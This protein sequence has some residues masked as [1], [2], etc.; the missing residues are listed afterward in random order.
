MSTNL[1]RDRPSGGTRRKCGPPAR[2]GDGQR[3]AFAAAPPDQ[4]TNM[5]RRAPSRPRERLCQRAIPGP[6]RTSLT[7][8]DRLPA[9]GKGIG[10]SRA[11]PYRLNGHADRPPRRSACGHCGGVSPYLFRWRG[12][13]L[14]ST[15]SARTGSAACHAF[16]AAVV[17]TKP[18]SAVAMMLSAQTANLPVPRVTT[19]TQAASVGPKANLRRARRPRVSRSDPVAHLAPGRGAAGRRCNRVRSGMAQRTRP[20][21]RLRMPAVTS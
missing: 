11:T 8:E 21:R 9:P 14:D 18:I 17:A 13:H 4:P 12:Q 7:R 6:R 19:G 20:P 3:E 16:E 2:G 5:E 1:F 15:T 10:Q